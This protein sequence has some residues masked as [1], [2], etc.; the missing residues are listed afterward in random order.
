M[1]L[2]NWSVIL[3]QQ[4]I[5]NDIRTSTLEYS[6]YKALNVGIIYLS[7]RQM[8]DKVTVEQSS[9]IMM[10]FNQDPWPIN[11]YVWITIMNYLPKLEAANR[12]NWNYYR[13][14]RFYTVLQQYLIF[15]IKLCDWLVSCSCIEVCIENELS[16]YSVTF[17]PEWIYS[18]I[19]LNVWWNFSFNALLQTS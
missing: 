16:L 13:V 3:W 5:Y 14:L 8:T 12:K 10:C 4:K 15:S 17:V 1:I 9:G 11:P 7:C 6:I 2:L 19:F 18:Y